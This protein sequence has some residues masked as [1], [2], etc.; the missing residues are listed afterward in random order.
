MSTLYRRYTTALQ[1]YLGTYRREIHRS[2]IVVA[3]HFTWMSEMTIK[4]ELSNYIKA[5]VWA[6]A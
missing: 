6:A 5:T 2:S 3:F 1:A 4:I